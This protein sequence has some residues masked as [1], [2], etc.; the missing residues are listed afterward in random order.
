MTS[1]N[2]PEGTAPNGPLTAI[3]A[4]NPGD[5]VD[6]GFYNAQDGVKGRDG[7]PYL[8]YEQ[9]FRAEQIR[10]RF[11]DR[12]EPVYGENVPAHVGTQLVTA[13]LV[14]D[15]SFTSNPSMAPRMGLE[16]VLTDETFEHEA[17]AS[18]LSVLPV[19]VEGPRIID[20]GE[21]AVGDGSVQ[22]QGN[23]T[24]ANPDANVQDKPKKAT[25]NSENKNP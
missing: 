25:A 9:R 16:A 3:S 21:A 2:V 18:P 4:P 7:G 15:N 1:P 22:D 5:T 19:Q 20:G 8:D 17:L 24:D 12:D 6:V 14:V 23:V 13:P 11:E 10:A